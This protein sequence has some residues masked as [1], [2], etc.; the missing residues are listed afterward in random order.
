MTIM[1]LGIM[2][3]AVFVI[4][5]I[6]DYM[7]LSNQKQELQGV[8]DR[9]AVA[10]AQELIVAKGSDAR[11]N[12]VATSFVD[13]NYTANAH[14]TTA[15]I[16]EKG[17]AVHVTIIAAP[18]TYFPGPIARG[19]KQLQV[20]ATA[21]ISGGGYVCMIGLD[22]NAPSTLNMSDKAR[23]TAENCAIY[24]NSK[25]KASLTLHNLSRVKAD[26]MCVAGGVQGPTSAVTPNAPITD[27]PPLLDPL[28]DRP[29]PKVGL[30][31]CDHLLTVLITALNGK[32]KLKPG[33]YCA[34]INIL[35]GDVTLEP[36]TYILNNGPLTVSGGG[37]LQGENVGFYLT[38]LLGLSSI[39][40]DPSSTISLT[41][42]KTGDMAGMLFFEDRRVL[43]K[44][45]HRIASNNARNLVGTIYLPN[46][47]LTIDS[48]NPI[49]DQSDYTVIIAKKFEMKDGPE[50][51][52]NTDYE[53]SPIP[54]PD[55]V[56]NKSRPMVRLAR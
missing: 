46:N 24:S 29:E 51:V 47:T 13:A 52:L 39:Q 18:Q 19:V 12:S 6:V 44:S 41:A 32:V 55:G 40:F 49:A 4:G 3:V 7:S 42:P 54:V 38:G 20:E 26:M 30:L 43:I 45:G 17:K 48:K 10:S 1:M 11:V 36:G 5:G 37:K 22:P 27:C 23:V 25:S 8:A 2:A 53:N 31:K 50:L 9:A 15:E 56:G 33:V 34:G 16:I 28:R 14:Q 35:G 21:E